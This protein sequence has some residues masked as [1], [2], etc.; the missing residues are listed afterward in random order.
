MSIGYNDLNDLIQNQRALAELVYGIK[1]HYD[2][3][4]SD[5]EYA[6]EVDAKIQQLSKEMTDTLDAFEIKI[7]DG[8]DKINSMV[9]Q[10]QDDAKALKEWIDDWKD[11]FVI[12]AD[13]HPTQVA[14]LLKGIVNVQNL[15]LSG[16]LRADGTRTDSMAGLED[17]LRVLEA[18]SPPLVIYPDG[19]ENDI[20]ITDRLPGVLYGRITNEVTDIESGQVIKISPYLQ[21]VVV[22]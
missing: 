20:P 12:D 13:G 5:I 6:K 2:E 17:R 14:E 22:D 21:G 8:S 18:K 4:Q 10:L 16:E 19:E 11:T 7:S 3:F 1:S 9:K 15:I